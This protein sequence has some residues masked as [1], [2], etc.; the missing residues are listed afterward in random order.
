MYLLIDT[1]S[2][3]VPLPNR[4][5]AE[6]RRGTMSDQFAIGVSGNDRLRF[7]HERR[8]AERLRGK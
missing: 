7:G 8:R 4:S 2:A 1:F 6:P 3:V 5:N